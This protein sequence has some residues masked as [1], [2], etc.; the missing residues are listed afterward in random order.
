MQQI[1]EIRQLVEGWAK[2]VRD[3]NMDGILAHHSDDIVMFDVPL[4][5]QA[6]GI[7]DYKKTWDLY[8]QYSKGGEGS[9]ELIDLQIRASETVAFCHALLRIGGPT[10][11]CRL[12]IGF[13]KI[14]GKWCITHE[15]HSA[16]SD[17]PPKLRS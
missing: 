1:D 11:E 3:G 4:P 13:Q 17:L 8:F 16:P 6:L 12:T 14:N 10:P 15:H 7:E 9:F 5:L 2:A